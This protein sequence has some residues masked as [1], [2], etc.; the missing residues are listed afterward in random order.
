ML[1]QTLFDSFKGGKR[2]L[3]SHV[4]GARVRRFVPTAGRSMRDPP[5]G[6][7]RGPPVARSS[8]GRV[9]ALCQGSKSLWG[10]A[11]WWQVLLVLLSARE[12]GGVLPRGP[13]VSFRNN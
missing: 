10:S 3:P 9:E 2:K 8:A 6:R 12:C 1:D 13:H 4:E 7:C 11:G 5:A